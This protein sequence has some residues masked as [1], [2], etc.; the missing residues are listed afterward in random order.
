MSSQEL[1]RRFFAA[2]AR[3]QDEAGLQE[4]VVYRAIG[5]PMVLFS[6]VDGSPLASLHLR[7]QETDTQCDDEGT[8]GRA[9]IFQRPD[10]RPSVVSSRPAASKPAEGT[11]ASSN[12]AA[13]FVAPAAVVAAAPNASVADK[14]AVSGP[15]GGAPL[16]AA[17]AAAAKASP[18]K[19][20]QGMSADGRQHFQGM[21]DR[22]GQEF[23]MVLT[24]LAT[25]GMINFNLIR[26][27]AD[28][29]VREVNPGG[30]N[31]VNELRPGESYV[32][33]CDQNA[34]NRP[35]KLCTIK[36][37]GGR[38]ALTVRQDLA[39]AERDPVAAQGLDLFLSVVPQLSDT[40]G[41]LVDR[42]A[43]TVWRCPASGL[44]VRPEPQPRFVAEAL[45]G[46]P[47]PRIG[48]RTPATAAVGGAV[49]SGACTGGAA[50]AGV[51]VHSIGGPPVFDTLVNAVNILGPQGSVPV[52]GAGRS[53]LLAAAGPS[54][55]SLFAETGR[56]VGKSAHKQKKNKVEVFGADRDVDMRAAAYVPP[57]LRAA[58]NL[59]ASAADAP[60]LLAD[61][62]ALTSLGT[63][64]RAAAVKGVRFAHRQKAECSTPL[65]RSESRSLEEDES[66]SGGV[67]DVERCAHVDRCADSSGAAGVGDGDVFDMVMDS[68]SARLEYGERHIT[69]NSSH[70]GHEYAY[71]RA[72]APCVLGLSVAPA[73]QFT[74][75][76][77][78]MT[79][80][81]LE[82]AARDLIIAFVERKYADFLA[83]KTYES[84]SCVICLDNGPDVCFVSCGHICTHRKCAASLQKCPVCRAEIAA[85]LQPRSQPS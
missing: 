31:Q 23:E 24:N 40:T 49:R 1:D 28:S 60:T 10:K 16:P 75:A 83:H 15:P 56:A 79:P 78:Q 29:V 76:D 77:R 70:T 50:R 43:K 68:K 71:D 53:G 36:D 84:D 72:G 64:G 66:S 41:Q 35:L 39:A 2:V 74:P 32:V 45:E 80:S 27:A 4:H 55:V 37:A 26:H 19:E 44:F 38:A 47:V 65:G 54:Y 7:C 21:I 48:G 22:D 34:N 59:A 30:V 58:R 63:S 14:K 12:L 57:P 46:G 18:S 33:Q 11:T 20:G 82:V 25:T 6:E 42:F 62:D 17:G 81:Q 85:R 69:V 9:V 13:P 52:S 5:F 51:V 67:Y 3:K 8:R 73:I 61:V